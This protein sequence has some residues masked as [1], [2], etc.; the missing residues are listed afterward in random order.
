MRYGAIDVGNSRVKIQIDSGAVFS[1]G[2]S[3]NNTDMLRKTVERLSADGGLNG[4]VWGVSSVVPWIS[5]DVLPE[6]LGDSTLVS[7]VELIDSQQVID[8]SHVQGAGHDRIMG[9][10]GALGHCKPP[11]I[12]VDC[13][14]AITINYVDEYSVFQGGA[15]LPG[16]YTAIQ[17]L[18]HR[19]E[20][21]P[22]L[23]P[24]IT[25][26]ISGKT[27]VDA[28]E[29]GNY[30]GAIG[31]ITTISERMMSDAKLDE[32][33]LVLTGGDHNLLMQGLDSK[34]C[35]SAPNLILEGI[36][37]LLLKHFKIDE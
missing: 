31:A 32:I 15:I 21:L 5:D 25:S 24:K 11:F 16:L 19:T 7:C 36:R 35:I 10:I 22:F 26:E 20:Q 9:L 4:Y 3:E 29:I 13:G 8:I 6:I 18:H 14:T 27:T 12:T 30:W 23:M 1:A 17:V 37:T 34:H 2:Y 28:M 33:P